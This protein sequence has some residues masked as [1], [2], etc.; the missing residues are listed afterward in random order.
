MPSHSFTRTELHQL[1]WSKPL[2]KLAAELG[3]SDV[4]LKKLCKRHD[5][6]TPPQGHWVSILHGKSRPTV[7]LPPKPEDDDP[8][9]RIGFAATLTPTAARAGIAALKTEARAKRDP[10]PLLDTPPDGAFDRITAIAA[11][12]FNVPIAIVSIV[13]ADRIWFKSHHGLDLGEIGRDAGLCASAILKSDPHILLDAKTDPN[14][15]ANPL[16]AGD[17]G[18]R[19]YAGAPL[20]TRDG[21]NLGTLCVI[22]RAP[23]PITEDQ[24][25]D[26]QDLASVVMD[27]IELR[28]A[29]RVAA[30]RANINGA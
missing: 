5:I 19:F 13:D 8:H 20:R 4:G 16:V 9:F 2:N 27:Q 29:A 12:R 7:P 3:L 21:F 30:E 25:A 23:R 1:I 14:A 22:D 18:L 11:R 17:F 15:L 28:L 10:A 26:L 24:I 6:P